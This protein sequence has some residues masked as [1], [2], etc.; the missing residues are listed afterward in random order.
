MVIP[1][2]RAAAAVVNRNEFLN[3]SLIGKSPY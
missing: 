3:A 1:V 2:T